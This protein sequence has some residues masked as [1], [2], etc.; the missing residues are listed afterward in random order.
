MSL[1]FIPAAQAPTSFSHTGDS[2]VV[3][4]A[5][6]TQ[7]QTVI[8]GDS[9]AV[10]AVGAYVAGLGRKVKT[11]DVSRAFHSHHMDGMLAD[12]EAVLDQVQFHPAKIPIVSSV[13]G[14][15]AEHALLETPDYWVAQVREAVRFSDAIQTMP[16]IGMDVFIELGARPVL[17]GMG[18]ACLG[19]DQR[20]CPV[21]LP[22][23]VGRKSGTHSMQNALAQLH[24]LGF[25]VDWLGYFKPY[26]CR[27][28]ELPTYA[29]QRKRVLSPKLPRL[30]KPRADT[31]QTSSG[32]SSPNT[33]ATPPDLELD[34]E[35]ALASML[36]N[37]PP[38]DW[39]ALV[40]GRVRRIVASLVGIESV[41]KIDT[42]VA[43]KDLGIDSLMEPQLRSQLIALAEVCTDEPLPR[44]VTSIYPD[45]RSFC[46]HL[47]SSS[48]KQSGNASF[49]EKE[50]LHLPF[51][52]R[53][54]ESYLDLKL[55]GI[56]QRAETLAFNNAS[57]IQWPPK[58]VFLTGAT[59]FVGAF[60][61]Q[62][63]LERGI[64]AHCLVRAGDSVQAMGD[65]EGALK[66]YDLW[67][68]SYEPFLKPIIGG[69]EQ[70]LFGLSQASFEE[71]SVQVDAICH[72]CAWTGGSRPAPDLIVPNL[73]GTYEVLHLASVDR[74]KPV[75]LVSIP[76]TIQPCVDGSHNVVQDDQHGYYHN[77]KCM[78]ERMVSAARSRGAKTSIFRLPL[79]FASSETGH[80][81]SEPDFLHLLIVGSLLMGKFPSLDG[82]LSAWMPIDYLCQAIAS[83]MMQNHSLP[84]NDVDF[85]HSQHPLSLKHVFTTISGA[86]EQ[87]HIVPLDE[88]RRCLLARAVSQP[89]GQLARVADIVSQWTDQEI[90]AMFKARPMDKHSPCEDHHTGA[91][92]ICPTSVIDETHLRKY[93][94]RIRLEQWQA[95]GIESATIKTSTKMH[96]NGVSISKSTSGTSVAYPVV[97]SPLR[98]ILCP[99]LGFYPPNSNL[100]RFTSAVGYFN[101][102]PWCFRLMNEPS[103]TRGLIPGSGRALAFLPHCFNP[104]S[105]Q[106]EQFIGEVLSRGR[107]VSVTANGKQGSCNANGAQP[108]LR[109]MLSLFRPST[110]GQVEDPTK[111]IL[112]VASL[113]AFGSGTSGFEGIVHGG[114]IATILDESLSIVSELNSALG[115]SGSAFNTVHV[116][117]SLNIQYLAPLPVTEDAV[118]VIASMDK[119][120]GRR[121][122]MKG[123]MV[124]SK[125][126]TLARVDSVWA[127]VP[128]NS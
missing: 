102:I 81:N 28:V 43:W 4:A 67:K 18:A 128:K 107:C 26:G 61:L 22:S 75:H 76:T 108:P 23:L 5:C 113:I 105:A 25:S 2:Q 123:E 118:C 100:D 90:L 50:S 14:R 20:P 84:N 98:R 45:M 55:A 10:D 103:P 66:N 71:L 56:S 80:F 115:K 17:S 31:D 120:D 11:L 9:R 111:P 126:N 62:Q 112:R 51:V 49:A 104:A 78:T 15:V 3:I 77:A 37:S 34:Q 88:W 35:V 8:S 57:H 19:I 106:H 92:D 42:D 68:E 96:L 89:A 73:V 63:L 29:F 109:H 59:G 13:T 99:S 24:Q 95:N 91:G 38:V 121:A 27:R 1:R 86:D 116:T 40:Q 122:I 41:D 64:T 85:V 125:G 60:L 30:P 101:K 6:N 110:P 114:L 83:A 74:G 119:L 70:P 97:L 12:F 21:W 33:T 124:D 39:P 47:L 16:G 52:P 94:A 53:N 127:G 48:R 117:A 79:I 72:L 7:S 87:Q 58:S 44:D 65:L 54:P 32:T 69:L 36:G 46:S 82:D 93:L